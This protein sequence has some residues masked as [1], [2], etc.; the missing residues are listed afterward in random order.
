MFP[1]T[2]EVGPPVVA[3]DP[4]VDADLAQI[5]DHGHADLQPFRVVRPGHRHGPEGDLRQPFPF[6]VA[7]LGQVLLGQFDVVGI[8]G[9]ILVV[10][11]HG[12]RDAVLGHFPHA[13]VDV[14]DDR[15][16]VD[17]VGDGLTQFEVL[18][19]LLFVVEPQVTD[20]HARLA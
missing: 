17:G 5:T 6:G 4:G 10:A 3:D 9:D 19:Q 15:L 11:P 2:L 8:S 18:P 16:P 14:V 7:G 13:L 1:L 12:G 20:V